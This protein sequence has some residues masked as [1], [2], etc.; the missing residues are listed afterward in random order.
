[1]EPVKTAYS[2]QRFSSGRQKKGTSL[3][4]QAKDAVELC[5]KMGW[6]LDESYFIDKGKSGFSGDNIVS[7]ALGQ[8]LAAIGTKVQ[9]GS[10]LIVES[11]DRLS[12]QEIHKAR[13]VMEQILEAGVE[14]HTISPERH[15][16]LKSLNDPFALIEILFIQSRANE[17][18]EAKSKR[19]KSNWDFK[20][21]KAKTKTIDKGQTAAPAG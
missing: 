15:Y 12:R 17:E 2:Y 6:L 7:G 10:V 13:K 18:S 8:F 1:M 4:R 20:R 19:S 14:I 16:D 9:R 3:K 21:E 11:L 5:Q